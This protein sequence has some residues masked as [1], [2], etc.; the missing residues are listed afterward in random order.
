MINLNSKQ[1][2]FTLVELTVVIAIIGIIAAIVLTFLGSSKSKG[3]DAKIQSHLRSMVSQAQLFTGTPTV[4]APSTAVAIPAGAAG[5][6]LFT[7]TNSTNSLYKLLSTLPSGT[8][9]YYAANA[10]TPVAG[11]KWAIAAS[12]SL[13]SFCVDYTGIGYNQTTT[14]MTTAASPGAS[15]GPVLYPNLA[16]SYTCN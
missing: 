1:K 3:N 5:G 11:G 13:G 2:G 6:N 16:G 9:V 12:T 4:A 14:V 15:S 7:D 10:T 8:V